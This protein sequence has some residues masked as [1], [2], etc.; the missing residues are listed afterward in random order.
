[1]LV[2]SVYSFYPKQIRVSWIRDGQEVPSGVVSTD[3]MADGD[4]FYQV[5]SLLEF[6]PRWVQVHSLLWVSAVLERK[7]G[8]SKVQNLI[9][10]SLKPP[11][12]ITHDSGG[13]VRP[14][15]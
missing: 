1:M 7:L 12:L 5:H 3:E 15:Q 2:C 10:S 14:V 4:W 13:P 6:T 8:S 9:A 11:R